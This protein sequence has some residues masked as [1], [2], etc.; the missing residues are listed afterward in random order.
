MTEWLNWTELNWLL[1][2]SLEVVKNMVL[3]L[4]VAGQQSRRSLYYTGSLE[5]ELKLPEMTGLPERPFENVS[6]LWPVR[7]RAPDASLEG[8]SWWESSLNQC[9]SP[10]LMFDMDVERTVPL[11]NSFSSW[12]VSLQIKY[13][14]VI[15]RDVAGCVR[16]EMEPKQ[17]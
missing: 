3:I 14:L 5:V 4:F 13:L 1:V 8:W 16:E 10:H 9:I 7:H 11:P 6:F 17:K 12:N 2:L 15:V